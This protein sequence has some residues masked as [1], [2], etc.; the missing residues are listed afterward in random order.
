MR[1]LWVFIAAFS[2]AGESDFI[3]NARQLTFEGKRAGEGYFSADGNKM[4]FQSER[5]ENNPFYQIYLLDLTNGD[6]EKVSPGT[7]KTTCA[8]IHPD[9]DRILFASNHQ[10]P[11]AIAQQKAELEFRASGKEKR[12]SWDYDPSYELWSKDLKTGKIDRLTDA[13]GYDAEASYSPD[14]RWIVFSS[15]RHIF[16]QELSKEQQELLERD[17]SVFLEL[18]IMRS[19][20]SDV[21]RLTNTLGYDGG[22]FFS[23]DG[24]SICF[25]RFREDGAVAEIYTMNTDGSNLKQLTRLDVMSWAPYYHPSGKYLIFATNRHGFAN[26]ELYLVDREGKKDPVRVTETDGFDGLPVFSPDGD[27]LSWTSTRTGNK[28]AQIFWADWNHE[29]AMAALGLTEAAVSLPETKAAVSEEDIRA[30][31]AYLSSP[32]LAGRLTGTEG[33]QLATAYVAEVFESLGLKP[34]GD[35]GSFYHSFDFVSGAELAD[36]CRFMIDGKSLE[37]DKDWRPLAFSAN[38]H[39]GPAPVAFAG[40]GIYAPKEGTLDAYDS[41]THMDVKG[42]WVLVFRYQPSDVNGEAT[43][44]LN[45]YADLRFKAMTAKDQG[46]VGILVAPGPLADVKEELVPLGFDASLSASG[47]PA[48]SITNAQAEMLIAKAGKDMTELQK[49]LDSGDLV[50][51]FD[52]PGIEVE[53]QVRVNHVKNKGRNV[54]GRLQSGD[55]PARKVVLIGAHVDHLGMGEQGHSLAKGEE[56]GAY[57]PGADDNA[58]GVAGVLEIAEYLAGLKE[59]GTLDVSHDFLFAAWSGEEMGLLGSNHFAAT[60]AGEGNELSSVMQAALNMDMI[61]RMEDKVVLQGLGSSPRWAAEIER[62]NVPFGLP[63]VT[64]QD[65]YLPTDATSF[66][67]K[68]VPVLSAFTGSHSEYH[69]P[70]DTADLLNYEGI[71]KIA[72]FMGA[73]A[74]SVA[75]DPEPLEYVKMERTKNAGRIGGLRA[76]LGTIPDYANTDIQG[77]LLSGVSKNGPAEKAG[78]QGGDVIVELAGKDVANIYDYTY[79]IQELKVGKTT[80]VTVMRDGEKHKLSVTPESRD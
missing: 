6:T 45:R 18:Y 3:Q 21:R 11:E 78:L 26:F 70:R 49:T 15:N 12:Y 37:T 64:Q 36:D 73:V 69:T 40:Y 56:K 19:D 58:S 47:L 34:E 41:Y 43:R 30:H 52:V 42:K 24:G 53:A 63:I 2:F 39:F 1:I 55:Q 28:Q 68:G 74:K 17:P 32:E 80:S 50:M 61:G 76:Y 51:G 27:T 22:P 48:I 35:Q 16:E 71:R 46:A 79:A 65:A 60:Y 66:Y 31:V 72:A 23:P 33:E 77:V 25:R 5:D 29:H 54:L 62:R 9:G 4:V 57:H 7:G 13:L 20:G 10:N 8:W 67:L 44:R 59:A 14:G 75:K 38:G